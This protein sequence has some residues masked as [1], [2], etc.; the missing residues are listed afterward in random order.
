[1]WAD[2]DSEVCIEGDIRLVGGRNERE[3]RIE[4]CF[5]GVWGTVCGDRYNNWDIN[6]AAVVCRQLGDL[7]AVQDITTMYIINNF[8][9]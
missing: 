5:V 4:V 9:L 7:E 8:R 1:M 6:D 3:G 2:P